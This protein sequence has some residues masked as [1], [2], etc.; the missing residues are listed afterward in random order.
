MKVYEYDEQIQYLLSEAD[1]ANDGEI[2]D[3]VFEE[4]EHLMLGREES[5][6]Y[7]LE[8][9]AL[10]QRTASIEAGAIKLE[11]MR[12]AERQAK[13]E[14]KAERLRAFMLD[15]MEREGVL[16]MTTER[17]IKLST[18]LS[19]ATEIEDPALIP[20][21]YFVHKDP[22]IDKATILREMRSGAVI[23]GVRLI[24]KRSIQIK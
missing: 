11:K 12:L 4:I 16:N 22:V 5:L 18:R 20:E 2:S 19:K 15:L 3:E 14:K 1:E 24:E 7:W 17:G 10:A 8:S 9:L 21:R 6:M 13:A 23:P